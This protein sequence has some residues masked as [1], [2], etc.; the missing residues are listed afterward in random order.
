M[1]AGVT[2]PSCQSGAIILGR[3]GGVLPLSAQAVKNSKLMRKLPTR[4]AIT[5]Y[6]QRFH[7]RPDHRRLRA[8][9]TGVCH[10]A[11]ESFEPV[12]ARAGGGVSEARRRA[13]HS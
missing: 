13:A 5:F 8:L 4:L 6:S 11:P 12:R 7:P 1:L 10:R 9:R 3:S 2:L